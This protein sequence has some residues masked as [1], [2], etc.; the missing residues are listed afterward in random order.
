MWRC[1]WMEL[2]M[3]QLQS[4]KL[5]YEK[6]LA[7][8][9]HTKQLDFGH[10]KLDGSDIKS[11][12]IT[13]RMH[14]NKVKRRNKRKKVE[15]NCDLNSYMSN[16]SLFSYYE[17]TDS[18]VDACLRDSN[19]VAVAIG[20]NDN[21]HEDLKLNDV[22]TSVYHVNIDNSFYETIQKIEAIEPQFLKLKTIFDKVISENQDR[23]PHYSSK[24]QSE[25]NMPKIENL[26]FLLLLFPLE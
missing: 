3:V 17:K 7:E 24:L 6:E 8:L 13:G 12:P 23:I 1:K 11:V 18:T 14:R 19:G 15:E 16:H 9:D 10:L 20:N 21:H 5:K 22:W 26:S 4:L 25:F 2:K